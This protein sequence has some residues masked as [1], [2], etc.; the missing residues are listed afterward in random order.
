[1]KDLL[2][3]QPVIKYSIYAAGMAGL[4]DSIHWAWVFIAFLV[5]FVK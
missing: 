5:R 4:F 3:D 1:M 2:A